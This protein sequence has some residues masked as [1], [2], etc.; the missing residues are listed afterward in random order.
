MQA[1]RTA[2]VAPNYCL[3]SR[4]APRRAPPHH[5]IFKFW[6]FRFSFVIIRVPL[7]SCPELDVRSVH[8]LSDRITSSLNITAQQWMSEIVPYPQTEGTPL[9]HARE[10]NRI[11]PVALHCIPVSSGRAYQ[12]GIQVIQFFLLKPL[13]LRSSERTNKWVASRKWGGCDVIIM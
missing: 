1:Q 4:P 3:Q 12:H 8:P 6:A 2:V 13:A 11:K 7:I 9:N 10:A 5:I